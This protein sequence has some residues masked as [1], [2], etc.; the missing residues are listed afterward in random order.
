VPTPKLA[1]LQKLQTDTFNK[2]KAEDKPTPVNFDI[3][4]MSTP[5]KNKVSALSKNIEDDIIKVVLDKGDPVAQWKDIVKEYDAKGVQ[6]TI[7]EVNAEA[8]KRGIK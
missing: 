5:A 3:Y 4:L 2:F 7:K 6:D 1:A 8:T